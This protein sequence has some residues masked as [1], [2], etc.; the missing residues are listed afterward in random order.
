[1]AELKTKRN[2]G[3]VE[4][5]LDS[6]EHDTR[7]EDARQVCAMLREI[8]GEQPAMWGDSII[9]FGSYDYRYET[10][11]TGSWPKLG[12]SPRKQSL[13]IYLT[14]GAGLH[15]D[16]LERLGPHKTGVSC[17]YV[18]R[19]ARIDE[20]VLREVLEASWANAAMGEATS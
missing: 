8:T 2:D 18:T 4:A 16:A 19:L 10:G 12:L 6:I 3:D 20:D 17:L 15:A 5:Y 13:T 9:G 11:R 1:M 14:D 7:R